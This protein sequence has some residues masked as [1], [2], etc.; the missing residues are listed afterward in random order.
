MAEEF[1]LQQVLGNGRGV[2]GHEGPVGARRMLV[3]R[4]RHQFLART[5]FTGDEHR[6]VALRKPADG[7]EHVLHGG[8]LAQHFGRGNHALFGHFL[9]LAFVDGAA[10]QLDGARQ[11]EGLGQVFEGAALERRNGAV[12]VGE[13]RHDDDG[14]AGVLGLDLVEQVEP[15]AA[16]H[17]DVAHQDLRA[18]LFVVGGKFEGGQHLA[19]VGE[20]ARGQVFAQQGLLQHE[21][22]RLVVIN[23]PDR[24]HASPCCRGC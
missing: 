19:R 2:D 11:V 3:Q 10:D 12:E 23:Y 4:T 7:A 21:A 9:A 24:L 20:A 15:G 6:D 17:A 16:G 14:Q 1:A 18:L 8:R 22:D 13:R 5:R